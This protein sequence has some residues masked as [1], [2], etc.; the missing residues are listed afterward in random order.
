MRSKCLKCWKVSEAKTRCK[1]RH[2]TR[3]VS[4]EQFSS[5]CDSDFLGRHPFQQRGARRVRIPDNFWIFLNPE[6]S[7][8]HLYSMLSPFSSLNMFRSSPLPTAPDSV[9]VL[10]SF[11][12]L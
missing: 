2:R 10:Y 3:I 8:L 12:F 9:P 11:P 7:I 1:L 4:F 5:S 6:G